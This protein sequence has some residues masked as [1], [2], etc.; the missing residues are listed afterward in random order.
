MKANIAVATVSGKSYYLIVTELKK[1]DLPFI[2]LTPDQPIPIE[3]KV[4]I[5]T[6]NEKQKI[7]HEHVLILDEDTEPEQLVNEAYQIIRGKANFQK[8]VIGIDPGQVFGLAVLADG[9][10]IQTDNCFSIQETTE[11]VKNTL[12][13]Y[14]DRPLL[15]A[16]VKIG[17]GVPAC[18]EALLKDL[19]ELLP[20]N[21]TLETV[22]EAGTNR[23]MHENKHRRGLRDIVSAIRIAGRN[24]HIYTRRDNQ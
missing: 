14:A 24:G 11:K 21:I 12:K 5:T 13:N 16:T 7:R 18:R 20:K 19:D 10:V 8:M 2:S 15:S 17:D 4:V 6:E 22:S 1:K 3:T 23:Y 9:K